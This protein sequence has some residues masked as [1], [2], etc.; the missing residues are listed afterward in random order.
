MMLIAEEIIEQIKEYY[1][2]P[3]ILENLKEVIKYKGEGNISLEFSSTLNKTGDK[4][5]LSLVLYNKYIESKIDNDRVFYRININKKDLSFSLSETWF[6]DI[7][8]RK[9][10]IKINSFADI[11]PFLFDGALITVTKI[12]TDERDKFD[13]CS[14]YKTC[15]DS[16][17]CVQ[18]VFDIAVGCKY[19]QKIRN[20]VIFY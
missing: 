19:W 5:S 18:P 3:D 6:P 17:A 4:I 14:R 8:K 12:G 10:T 2:K 11:E 9:R 1:L 13:C 7:E 15:S 20:G 16:K